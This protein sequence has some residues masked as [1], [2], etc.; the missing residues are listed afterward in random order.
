[1]L[2]STFAVRRGGELNT[3]IDYCSNFLFAASYS[4]SFKI[5]YVLG[6]AKEPPSRG[7]SSRPP[8]SLFAM[9]SSAKTSASSSG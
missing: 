3:G 2:S 8:S 9:I 7:G 5:P 1:M 4:W 6:E